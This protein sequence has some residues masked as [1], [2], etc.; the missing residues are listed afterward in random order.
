MSLL[1]SYSFDKLSFVDMGKIWSIFR[2]VASLNSKGC[3]CT[4][5]VVEA[6]L[7]GT[8]ELK[9]FDV[10]GNVIF[11][12]ERYERKVEKNR[13]L[14]Q[15]RRHKREKILLDDYDDVEDG[16]VVAD[17]IPA[18]HTEDIAE[19]IVDHAELEWALK[20]V[21]ERFNELLACERVDIRVA[22]LQANKGIPESIQLVKNIVYEYP[23]VGEA[24][25]V[26]LS[27]GIPLNEVVKV[28]Y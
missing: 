15:A 26:I 23:L 3:S 2:S 11:D 19:S 6:V 5:E 12:L 21:D 17:M 10:D 1:R 7:D 20:Y 18:L 22:L 13:R 8:L 24:I 25:H 14:E 9:Y 4:L 16:G 27:C 28:S